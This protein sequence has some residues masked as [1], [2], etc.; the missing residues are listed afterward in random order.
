MINVEYSKDKIPNYLL[1]NCRSLYQIFILHTQYL[2]HHHFS[3]KTIKELYLEI[4]INGY[5]PSIDA[6]LLHI[7]KSHKFRVRNGVEIIHYTFLKTIIC[8][9]VHI[10]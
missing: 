1:I 10:I 8:F 4:P 6:Y 5:I 9:A 2:V 7:H 3:L